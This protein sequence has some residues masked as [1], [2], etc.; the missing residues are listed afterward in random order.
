[1]NF[2]GFFSKK[3]IGAGPDPATWAGPKLARPKDMLII[4]PLHAEFIL[5]ATIAAVDNGDKAGMED[6]L[7]W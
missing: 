1:L 7:R 2:F 3:K 4:L 5:Q 6:H